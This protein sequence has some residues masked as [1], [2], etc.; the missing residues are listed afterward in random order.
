KNQD[1]L[2]VSSSDFN[3]RRVQIRAQQI[4]DI[5]NQRLVGF[6]QELEPLLTKI[7]SGQ[8]SGSDKGASD[9]G[10]AREDLRVDIMLLAGQSAQFPAV[11]RIFQDVARHPI[12]FVR[13]TLGQPLLK[14][15]VS[16]G[17]LYYISHLD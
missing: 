10:P 17:A 13:D 9:S 1:E 2:T 4:I 3:H 11:A 7:L 12:D 6:K 15:C 5:F 14:E 16:R 8:A